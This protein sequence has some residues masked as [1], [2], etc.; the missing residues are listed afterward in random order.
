[1]YASFTV[2]TPAEICRFLSRQ[3]P[4]LSFNI[5]VL[6]LHRS[7][8]NNAARPSV[9]T[10]VSHCFSL[11]IDLLIGEDDD[12][13]GKDYRVSAESSISPVLAGGG[14]SSSSRSPTPGILSTPAVIVTSRGAMIEPSASPSPSTPRLTTATVRR[15]I[16][17]CVKNAFR[18]GVDACA[19]SESSCYASSYVDE[20]ERYMYKRTPLSSEPSSSGRS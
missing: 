10:V 14:A 4:P 15:Q 1:M 2:D 13:N 3:C 11:V 19:D 20:S 17:R 16:R 5:R 6:L 9:F 18:R 12:G 7:T 8:P